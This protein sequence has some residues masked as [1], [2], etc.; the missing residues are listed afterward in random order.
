M[1]AVT[2]MDKMAC[3]ETMVVCLVVLVWLRKTVL[4]RV[5]V[6]AQGGGLF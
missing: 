4:V 2:S 5:C 3:D 6:L 1:M